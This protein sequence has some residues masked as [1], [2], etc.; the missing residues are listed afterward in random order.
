MLA[1]VTATRNSMAT[2]PDMLASARASH[3]RARHVFVD[4]ESTDG[5]PEY[6]RT[7]VDDNPGARL[8]GQRSTGLYEALNEGIRAAL[9]DREVTRIGML[10]S[11]DRLV[12]DRYAEYLGH[13]ET[14][15]AAFHYADIEYHDADGRVVRRWRAGD[16]S[17][18]KLN[19]GWM[20]P[21]TSVVVSKDVYRSSGLYNPSFGT[22][23][24]Y[25]WMVRVLL[26]R[27]DRIRYFPKR[28]LSMRV[29]GASNASLTARLEANRQ[30]GRV[31]ARRS[32]LQSLLVR[33]CKPA[34]KIGQF[35]WRSA[36]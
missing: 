17:R 7:W 27:P 30:D 29:G 36:T 21:H 4:G 12:G 19:T 34:R 2:L 33:V 13:I 10:H 5:T 26:N 35:S 8:L 28:V 18:F 24:D 11:D 1:L 32:R 6:L 31:W 9:D 3:G 16:Y 20:P 14:S 22:A 15:D 25:E 23:A